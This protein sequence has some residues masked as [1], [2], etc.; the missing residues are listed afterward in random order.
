LAMEIGISDPANYALRNA[1][2][3]V[4]QFPDFEQVAERFRESAMV[5]CRF[6]GGVYALPELRLCSILYYRKALLAALELDVRD[7][8]DDVYNMIPELQKRYMQFGIPVQDQTT[9][10]MVPND[11]FS[12][13]LFQ[14]DGEYY[15]ED[16]KRSALDSEISMQAFL[17]WTDF[18]TSYKFPVQYD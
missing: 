4:S 9:A 2:Y 12:M 16:G 10:T 13:L 11:A 1:A 5:P 7:T 17:Q 8:C 3:D 18:Y 6:N 15:V 14:M